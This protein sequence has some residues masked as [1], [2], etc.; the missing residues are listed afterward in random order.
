VT[1]TLV[2]RLRYWQ[3]EVIGFNLQERQTIA[4]LLKEAAD[5]MEA[6]ATKVKRLQAQQPLPPGAFRHPTGFGT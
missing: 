3:R 4:D 6:C 1:T 2:D 5:G